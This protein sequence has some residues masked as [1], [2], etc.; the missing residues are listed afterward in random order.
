MSSFSERDGDERGAAPDFADDTDIR[1]QD[2]NIKCIFMNL[3]L[4]S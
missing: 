1:N 3:E 2:V 4:I